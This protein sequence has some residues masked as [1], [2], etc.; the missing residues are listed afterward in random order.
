MLRRLPNIKTT[1]SV[2]ADLWMVAKDQRWELSAMLSEAI[3]E[4]VE[5]LRA[6]MD[7]VA[8]KAVVRPD[9]SGPIHEPTADFE[10]WGSWIDSHPELDKTDLTATDKMRMYWEA[11]CAVTK[12]PFPERLKVKPIVIA[13]EAA[14]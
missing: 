11:R 7:E 14:P 12:E 6:K 8:V 10:P 1:V 3:R 9:A 13:P 4:R 2:P 5:R